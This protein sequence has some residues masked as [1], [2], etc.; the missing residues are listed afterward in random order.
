MPINLNG[1]SDLLRAIR[2]EVSLSGMRVMAGG[3]AF[4]A[5]KLAG[6]DIG[7]D[8]TADDAEGAVKAAKELFG[9]T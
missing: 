2:G 6:K 4:A 3:Q 7:A 8:A 5:R 1:A 9:L